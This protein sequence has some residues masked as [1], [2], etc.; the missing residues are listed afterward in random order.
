ML[1]RELMTPNPAC[2]KT[3]DSIQ[4]AARMLGSYDVGSLPVVEGNEGNR[5]VGIVTDRDLVINALAEG[6]FDAT[7]G[8]VMTAQPHAARENDDVA[9]VQQVMSEE[10]VRR[11]PVVNE[12]GAVVGIISQADLALAGSGVSERQVAKMVERISEPTPSTPSTPRPIISP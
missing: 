6:N 2:C 3:S 5:L 8:D 1:A 7:V 4:A 12:Q 10:Q 11:V 9:R